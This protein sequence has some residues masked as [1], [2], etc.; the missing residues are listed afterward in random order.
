MAQAVLFPGIVSSLRTL[1][2]DDEELIGSVLQDYFRG[3][4]HDVRCAAELAE[5]KAMVAAA[6]YD[7]VVSDLRLSGLHGA[8]GFEL[9][10]YLR[11]CHP[12]I[13]SVVL[14]AF[15]TPEIEREALARGASLVLQKP[16]PLGSL[17]EAIEGLRHERA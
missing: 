11:A 3:R 7:V 13:R 2:V 12:R 17:L 8:E 6:P 4:G 16:Q 5:A 15:G 14:T 10:T 1:I 9:V